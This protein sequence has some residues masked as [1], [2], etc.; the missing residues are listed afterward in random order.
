MTSLDDNQEQFTFRNGTEFVIKR[1]DRTVRGVIYIKSNRWLLRIYKS[2]NYPEV[3][4]MLEFNFQPNST[5][6]SQQPTT[7]VKATFVAN[8]VVTIRKYKKVK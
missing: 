3:K 8:N 6:D 7:T 5:K 4:G 1:E 2:D